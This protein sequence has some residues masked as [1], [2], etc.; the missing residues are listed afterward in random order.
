MKYMSYI[1][2]R[3][4]QLLVAV[5]FMIFSGWACGGSSGDE[6]LE[7]DEDEDAVL[8]I[9]TSDEIDEFTVEVGFHENVRPLTSSG[10]L[11][12]N[13]WILF[14]ENIEAVFSRSGL[15][16]NVP[17]QVGDADAKKD[18]DGNELSDDDLETL[19]K[20]KMLP[21]SISREDRFS[22]RDIV[23]VSK[24]VRLVEP[25]DSKKT[26]HIMLLPGKFEDAD[27]DI[28]D[29]TLGIQIH[30]KGIIAIFMDVLVAEYDNE[31][32]AQLLALTHEFGH[33]AGLVDKA[34]EPQRDAHHD[35]DEDHGADH[36]T[37]TDCIMF[38][39]LESSAGVNSFLDAHNFSGDPV[40]FGN[41]CIDDIEAVRG[42]G[43]EP[44][45]DDPDPDDPD[46]DDPDPDDP[47]PDDPGMPP[48]AQSDGSCADL[49]S[50]CPDLCE[51]VVATGDENECQLLL[52]ALQSID[53]C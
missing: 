40:L 51:D 30:G 18:S 42:G 20:Q 5:S 17:T 47:D 26:L 33:F 3:H 8:Q 50:C 6:G 46:P 29:S 37:N 35:K 27:G 4:M 12:E 13:P 24:Q 23:D 2:F 32:G 53:S 48:V 21:F 11:G 9:Y 34:L 31:E 19:A 14:K 38:W 10:S 39:K 25:T 41:D 52:E 7:L 43:S 36:C 45:L 1:N 28:R 16:V 22:A 15:T 44:D 49:E